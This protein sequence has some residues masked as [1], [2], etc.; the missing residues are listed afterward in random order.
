MAIADLRI[1]FIVKIVCVAVLS[2]YVGSEV[3]AS[4]AAVSAN[5]LAGDASAKEPLIRK[6][7]LLILGG[8]NARNGLSAAQLS[9]SGCSA[10]NLAVSSELGD[11]DRYVAWLAK[12]AEADLIIY[13]SVFALSSSPATK[14]DLLD[15]INHLVPIVSRL[16]IIFLGVSSASDEF[17]NFGDVT[18]YRCSSGFVVQYVDAASF[19]LS[20]PKV[21]SDLARRVSRLK[22]ITGAKVVMLH[23]PRLYLNGR[24]HDILKSIRKRQAAIRRAGISLLDTPVVYSDKSLFCDQWHANA[25]GR[26]QFTSDIIGA[27]SKLGQ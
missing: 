19:D 20:T 21:V 23:M 6:A 15:P 22:S 3:R 11:F 9:A 14:A 2:W 24:D 26:H 5:Y 25:R 27:L 1:E 18:Q 7:C 13:S 12:G 10:L 16:K 4:R 8:S 17:T